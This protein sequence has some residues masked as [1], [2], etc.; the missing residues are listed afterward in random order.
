MNG[1]TN[2][3]IKDYC[4]RVNCLWSQEAHKALHRTAI[5]LAPFDN[6]R[7]FSSIA[8]GEL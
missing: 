6:L 3:D 1:E 5:P 7:T 4:Q 8:A 2:G